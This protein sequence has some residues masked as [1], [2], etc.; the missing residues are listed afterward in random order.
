MCTISIAMTTYNGGKYLGE[1]LES[2]V[3]QTRQPDEIIIVDDCSKDNTTDI[4]RKFQ[5]KHSFIKLIVNE[6]N[7]G[8]NGNFVKALENSKGDYIIFCDQDD[9]WKKEKVQTLFHKIKEIEVKGTPTIVSSAAT[10]VN[11]NM[12]V[13]GRIGPLKDNSDF[14]NTVLKHY[15]QGCTMILNRECIKYASLIPSYNNKTKICFDYVLG[16]IVAF[17]GI[18][19]D[20][21]DE[22][23]YYRRHGDNVTTA[24][25][26]LQKTLKERLLEKFQPNIVHHDFIATDLLVFDFLKSKGYNELPVLEDIVKIHRLNFCNKLTVALKAKY[27]SLSKRF[28]LCRNIVINEILTK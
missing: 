27:L 9:I 14:R 1:Q 24:S 13:V 21:S 5:K 7:V 20:L 15:S 16:L 22:L 23:M 19:Y 18:K 25:N 8:V 10:C 11:N 4:V 17:V 2:L 28:S 26:S 3:Y 6:K 12:E